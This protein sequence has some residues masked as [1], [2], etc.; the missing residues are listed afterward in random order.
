MSEEM[1]CGSCGQPLS[2]RS[3][4]C[5]S[6]GWDSTTSIVAAKKIPLSKVLLAAGWRALVYG[7]VLAIPFLFFVRFRETGPGPDL[8]TTLRWIIQG[9][10]GRSAELITIHR[11]YEIGCA[12]SRYAVIEQEALPIMEGWEDVLAPLSTGRVR[13]WLPVPFIGGLNADMVGDAV[14]EIYDV[15]LSDG[16]GRPYRL[17]GRELP[18]RRDRSWA[19]DEQVA[20]DLA[21]GLNSSFFRRGEPDFGALVG[22]LRLQIESAG[23]DGRFDTED[24]LLMVSYIQIG[25]T[26]HLQE[27]NESRRRRLEA[28]YNTGPHL[29]RLEGSR[30]DLIEARFLAE[31]RFEMV[32]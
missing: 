23:R 16:W 3:S 2:P 20:K 9:D 28:A 24:D 6:C 12:A 7:L 11:A 26:F 4:I 10:E 32:W 31:H 29:F 25:Q 21:R 17:T 1:I 18:S 8:A 30:Y 22:W 14:R 19:E 15:R 27:S 5:S 13:G